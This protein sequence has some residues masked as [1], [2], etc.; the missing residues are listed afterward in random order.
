MTTDARNGKSELI[1]AAKTV[2]KQPK[3]VTKKVCGA[4]TEKASD[5][6]VLEAVLDIGV[7]VKE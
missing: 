4:R 6:Q 5:L 3:F 1:N 2:K 7:D